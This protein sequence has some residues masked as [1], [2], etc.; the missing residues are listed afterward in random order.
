MSS[1][2]EVL[3]NE[4]TDLVNAGQFAEALVKADAALAIDPSSSGAALARA[5]CLSQLGN[6]SEASA[7]FDAAIRLAPGD[8]KARFNAAVHEYNAGNVDLARSLANQALDLDAS[9]KGAKSLLQRMP[10][11]ANQVS[12]PRDQEMGAEVAHAGLPFITKMGGGWVGLGWT[13]TVV[14][15]LLFANMLMTVL[16]KFSEMMAAAQANDQAKSAAIQASM[17][18]PAMQVIGY[19]HLALVVV[20]MILDLIHRKGNMLWLIA[21]IPCS[22]CGGSF[23]TLPLYILFGRK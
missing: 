6:S 5:V 19:L 9:H 4:C 16:P 7:A 11:A 10:A 18:N 20:W 13:L 8:A 23:L 15:V 14:S 21:H 22:C 17:T 2:L 12:Y 3:V 1:Q